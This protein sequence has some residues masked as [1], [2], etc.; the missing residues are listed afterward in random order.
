MKKGIFLIGI[1][2]LL[3][4][5]SCGNSSQNSNGAEQK[6][7]AENIEDCDDFLEQYEKWGDE[8]LKVLDDYFKNP[9][10]QEITMRYMELMQEAMEWST[11][12]SALM[13]CAEDEKYEKKFEAISNEL[14]EKMKELNL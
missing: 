12:W 14:E 7:N 4:A 11:K 8:Y 5:Y 6:L 2:V 13:D 1:I 10:D 3:F 9:S